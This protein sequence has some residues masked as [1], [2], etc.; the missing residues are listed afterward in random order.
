MQVLLQSLHSVLLRVL[1]AR[2]GDYFEAGSFYAGVRA[3]HRRRAKATPKR[4]ATNSEPIGASRAILLRMLKGIPGFRPASIAPFT[5]S[6]DP[7]TA[8]ETSAK[9]DLASRTGSRP[10]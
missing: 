10:S 4:N 3:P 5:R 9:A 2:L 8:F 1:R 7:L 6:T